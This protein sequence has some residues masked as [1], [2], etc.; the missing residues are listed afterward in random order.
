QKAKK[1][2]GPK[3]KDEENVE[4]FLA[5]KK[6]VLS[7]PRIEKGRVIIEIERKEVRAERILKKFLKSTKKGER[8]AIRKSLKRPNVLSEKDLLKIYKGEF[9]EFF[10]HYLEGKESFE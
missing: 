8:N 5:N 7:G 3:V 2:L 9:A 1:V 10:T 4:R 6:K